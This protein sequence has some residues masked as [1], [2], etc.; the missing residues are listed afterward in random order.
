MESTN[1]GQNPMEKK[2]FCPRHQNGKRKLE[3]LS[4]LTKAIFT[5]MI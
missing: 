4:Q 2:E 3:F 5:F 1:L